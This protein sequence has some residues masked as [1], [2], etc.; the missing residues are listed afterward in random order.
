MTLLSFA[1]QSLRLWAGGLLLWCGVVFT[2]IGVTGILGERRYR[3]DARVARGQIVAK[4]LQRAT[5]N[6]STRYEILYRVA[7]P[8]GTVERTV[9]VDVAE[10]ERLEQGAG[11]DVQYL[12]GD[13]DSL[14]LAREPTFATHAVFCALGGALT[15]V[16]AVLVTLGGRD[17]RRKTRLY[18]HGTPAVATVVAIEAT[19][20][21]INRKPQWRIRFRYEDRGG[22]EREGRSG[23]L[24]ASEAHA[25]NRGDSGVVHFDPGHPEHVLW[26]G[27]S[28]AAP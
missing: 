5:S 7:L 1:R 17:V 12:P 25:W 18:R 3:D 6:T 22:Q 15:P 23:Y 20:V 10:W 8:D 24:P 21:T 2:W 19:N 9:P 16:G 11:V 13:H 4:S 26:I 27:Q 14:R 28:R